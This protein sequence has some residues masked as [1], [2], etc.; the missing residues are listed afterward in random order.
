MD[1]AT[2]PARR[3]L[4]RLRTRLAGA[5]AGACV[6]VLALTLI[7]AALIRL[8][9]DNR[10]DPDAITAH[11]VSTLVGYDSVDLAELLNE[12]RYQLPELEAPPPP[13]PPPRAERRISGFVMVEVVV[14]A[15]GRAEQARVIEAAPSGV[16]EAQAIEDAL[17]GSYEAGRPGVQD[18]IVRF[19]VPAEDA[20]L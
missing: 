16:Y 1:R 6:V 12:P 5:F 15:E 20:T 3:D 9:D 7:G 2:S 11:P 4:P 8:F 19:S 10:R 14:D 13:L 18:T 17:A